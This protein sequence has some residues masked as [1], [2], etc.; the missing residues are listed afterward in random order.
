MVGNSQPCVPAACIPPCRPLSPLPNTALAPASVYMG[1]IPYT[2][3]PMNKLQYILGYPCIL[4]EILAYPRL[5][6]MGDILGH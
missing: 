1:D 4:L 2:L 3:L 5:L 6:F